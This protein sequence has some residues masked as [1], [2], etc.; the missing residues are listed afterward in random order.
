MIH[1]WLGYVHTSTGYGGFA[2]WR[3][4]LPDIND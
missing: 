3:F 4:R 1:G 2:L